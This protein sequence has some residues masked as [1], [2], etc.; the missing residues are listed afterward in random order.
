MMRYLRNPP[1]FSPPLFS[2]S[3]DSSTIA[4]ELSRFA[5]SSRLAVY[6]GVLNITSHKSDGRLKRRS[7]TSGRSTICEHTLARKPRGARHYR[8]SNP[9][10]TPICFSNPTKS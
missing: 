6:S 4:R 9:Y 2:S 8:T 3:I 1:D 10:I 5:I 7:G